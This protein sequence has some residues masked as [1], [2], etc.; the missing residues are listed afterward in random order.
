[1]TDIILRW[2]DGND[3]ALAELVPLVSAP[4]GSR[5]DKRFLGID[6]G[7]LNFAPRC[8][9]DCSAAQLRES[10]RGDPK[11]RNSGRPKPEAKTGNSLPSGANS[12]MSPSGIGF[13]SATKRLPELSKAMPR[14][15]VRPVAKVLSMPSGV[16]LR[17][18]SLPGSQKKGAIRLR[19]LGMVA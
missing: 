15:V 19:Q 13:A 6:V 2:N 8:K 7:Y 14:G 16:N 9:M 4:I 18:V 3:A 1:V 17:I 12:K 5:L 10:Y 11:V